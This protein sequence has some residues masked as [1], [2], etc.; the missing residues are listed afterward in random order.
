MALIEARRRAS[1]VDN[2]DAGIPDRG[3]RRM[4]RPSDLATVAQGMN[5]NRDGGLDYLDD[6]GRI[7]VKE[8]HFH[9]S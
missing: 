4:N 2:Y 7:V 3:Y 9:V 6:R 8:F 5:L 1:K